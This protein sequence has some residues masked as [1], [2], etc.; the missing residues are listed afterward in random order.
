MK[1]LI[2]TKLGRVM[3]LSAVAMAMCLM[4]CVDLSGNNSGGDD[5]TGGNNT[6]GGGNM[7][8][9]GWY[10]DGSAEN[11]TITTKT[12]LEGLA[13]IVQG[14]SGKGIPPQD[15]FRGKTITLGAD[16][17]LNNQAWKSIGYTYYPRA[18]PFNGTF[19]GNNKTISNLK[20]DNQGFFGWIGG[21]GIVQNLNFVNV[22]VSGSD[23]TGGIVRSNEGVIQ[24][25]NVSNGIVNDDIVGAGGVAWGN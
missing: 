4:G 6:N 9:Y 21:Y 20:C 2:L 19:D 25:V 11:Y 17:N 3:L 13:N 5:N 7:P 10:G 23:G 22:L 18:S 15:D 8:N 16:I 14:V 24:Y 1:D 12:Q